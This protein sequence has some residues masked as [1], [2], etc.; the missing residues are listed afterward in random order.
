MRQTSHPALDE[1]AARLER[2]RRQMHEPATGLRPW[3][4][5]RRVAARCRALVS[6]L[7]ATPE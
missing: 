1:F 7:R 2:I 5:F 4:P 6:R 3:L